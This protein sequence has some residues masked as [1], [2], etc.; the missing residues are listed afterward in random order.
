MKNNISFAFKT[1]THNYLVSQTTVYSNLFKYKESHDE[2]MNFNGS[3]LSITGDISENSELKN[4]TNY[5]K[6][7]ELSLEIDVNC[8]HIAKF[9]SDTI[10]QSLKTRNPFSSQVIVI[11][12]DDVVLVDQYGYLF[13]DNIVFTG[14]GG[15][16][17]YGIYDSYKNT[18]ENNCDEVAI[19]DFI[20]KCLAT[21]KEKFIMEANNWR[22]DKIDRNGTINT[23]FITI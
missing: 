22:I 1:D 16:F 12:K 7:V 18:L 11:D 6:Y 4:L 14:F 5:L 9:L 19:N 20:S 23:G 17:L 15:Y 10:Y 3:L 21:L 8:N 2:V 13:K